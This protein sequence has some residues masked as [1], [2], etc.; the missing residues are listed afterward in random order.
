MQVPFSGWPLVA[1][2]AKQADP[3]PFLHLPATVSTQ[4]GM[5]VAYPKLMPKA[6]APFLVV[7]FPHQF[8]FHLG[9]VPGRQWGGAG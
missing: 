9:D 4:P 3:G 7:P 1:V 2:P 5:T 8:V 6:K